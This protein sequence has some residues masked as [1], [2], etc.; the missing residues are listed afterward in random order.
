[1]VQEVN[2]L[3]NCHCLKYSLLNKIHSVRNI[4]FILLLFFTFSAKAQLGYEEFI[5]EKELQA[6][7]QRAK[8]KKEQMYAI[9]RLALHLKKLRRDSIGEI[10]IKRVYAL[11]ENEKDVQAMADALWWRLVY[12]TSTGDFDFDTCLQLG[13]GFLSYADHHRGW[14]KTSIPAIAV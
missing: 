4:V 9:G 6:N 14:L 5:G 2:L 8:T 1:M 12:E 3:F 7:L 13:N 11:A 10:Y